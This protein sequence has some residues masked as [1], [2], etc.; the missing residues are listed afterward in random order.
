MGNLEPRDE[1]TGLDGARKEPW[2]FVTNL[3]QWFPPEG[4]TVKK[5]RSHKTIR[6]IRLLR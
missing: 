2:R 1:K 4:S 3:R 5:R 6:R